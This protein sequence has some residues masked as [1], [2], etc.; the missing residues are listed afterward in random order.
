MYYDKALS[1]TGNYND[2]IWRLGNATLTR[3]ADGSTVNVTANWGS[4]SLR[5]TSTVANVDVT[6]GICI[7][8]DLIEKTESANFQWRRSSDNGYDAM[9]IYL[10]HHKHIVYNDKQL[11][12]VDGEIQYG[13]WITKNLGDTIQISGYCGDS[14]KSFKFANFKVYPT[15]TPR[16]S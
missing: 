16:P 5:T 15:D 12:T 13:G 10:G 11:Y 14:T 9:P 4:V 7:E 6:N 8:Y 2:A 3:G 1:G